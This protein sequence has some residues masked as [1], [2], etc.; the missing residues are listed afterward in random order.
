MSVYVMSDIHGY[1]DVLQTMLK[2]IDF[3]DEDELIIAGDYIDRGPQSLEMLRW[4]EN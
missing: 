3:S 4:M 1:F 2:K